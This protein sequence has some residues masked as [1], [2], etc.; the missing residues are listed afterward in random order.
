MECPE[1]ISIFPFFSNHYDFD[2]ILPQTEYSVAIRRVDREY[3]TI[4]HG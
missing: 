2:N 4:W 1:Y 3:Y